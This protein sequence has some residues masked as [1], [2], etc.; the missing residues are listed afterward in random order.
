M[1]PA[2]NLPAASCTSPAAG[3]SFASQVRAG[4]AVVSNPL[5]PEIRRAGVTLSR[6]FSSP[7]GYSKG[8]RKSGRL[9]GAR[10]PRVRLPGGE[11]RAAPSGDDRTHQ[12]GFAGLTPWRVGYTP[13]AAE[14][15]DASNGTG[16][17]VRRCGTGRKDSSRV[18]LEARNTRQGAA[19]AHDPKDATAHQF[20]S[21]GSL[22]HAQTFRPVV[23]FSRWAR[24]GSGAFGV[25]MGIWAAGPISVLSPSALEARDRASVEVGGVAAA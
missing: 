25:R 24:S 22:D 12:I 13:R 15:C 17:P 6:A 7:A 4:A 8:V 5:V 18:I 1:R 21:A 2:R 23:R 3:S 9:F 14:R 11:S 10:R 16:C 19:G 20:M